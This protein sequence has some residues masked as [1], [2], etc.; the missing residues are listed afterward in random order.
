MK[1]LGAEAEV[2]WAVTPSGLQITPP[3]DLGRSEY[4]WTFEIVT[5][6]EQHT[7]NV[8]VTDATKALKN[9]RKVDLEGHDPGN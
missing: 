3:S 1:L 6:E 7:P 8:M 5:N 4:A 9:T 2:Q